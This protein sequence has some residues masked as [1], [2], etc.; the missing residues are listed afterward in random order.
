MTKQVRQARAPSRN[1]WLLVGAG[2]LAVSAQL[3][4]GVA[5][6]F[7]SAIE[8]PGSP[9]V[10]PP[11]AMAQTLPADA[12]IKESPPADDPRQRALQPA[13]RRT[14]Y[15]CVAS[16][17]ACRCSTTQ[18]ARVHVAEAMCREIAMHGDVWVLKR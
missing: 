6:F 2:V 5:V 7:P 15:V 17:A 14:R 18:G 12:S 3:A 8:H 11:Q 13:P 10:G 9:P 1:S 4:I 16:D